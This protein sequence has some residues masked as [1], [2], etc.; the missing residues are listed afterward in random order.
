MNEILT[1][2]EEI[3]RKDCKIN[4][5]GGVY[6]LHEVNEPNYPITNI[7]QKGK[8]LLYSFDT[9]GSNDTLFWL[10]N[11]SLKGLTSICDYILF[12]PFQDT[13][14][15]FLCDL[16]SSQTSAKVQVETGQVVA[17]LI[18]KMLEKHLKFRQKIKIEYR[19]LVLSTSQRAKFSTNM[20]QKYVLL[21]GSN[22]ENKLLKAGQD[23]FLDNL[24]F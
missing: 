15:V 9:E 12:Y 20:K 3:L 1:T 23:I 17:Q 7:K 4:P 24:C 8:L 16:K 13:F 5:Q 11:S 21:E 6:C 19:S 2:L 10:F 14:F 22:L 18:I